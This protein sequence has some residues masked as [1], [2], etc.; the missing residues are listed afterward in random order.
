MLACAATAMPSSSSPSCSLHTS[1]PSS[2]THLDLSENSLSRCL[3]ALLTQLSSSLQNITVLEVEDVRLDEAQL[4][5]LVST[6]SSL[7]R[8]EVV[9]MAKRSINFYL[10]LRD[11]SPASKRVIDDTI[12]E[13]IKR[14]NNHRRS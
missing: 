7:D 2:L 11:M 10:L 8:L 12:R 9:N 3:P 4:A 13:V 6:L 14:I 5:A 1:L